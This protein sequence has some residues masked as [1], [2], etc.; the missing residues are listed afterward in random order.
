[1]I[2]EI[3]IKDA[4]VSELI[5]I[6]GVDYQD[7]VWDVETEA[8]IPNPQTKAEFANEEFD[9][10]LKEFIKNKVMKY[11]TQIATNSIDYTLITE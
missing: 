8:Q 1:M 7:E 3:I 4:Y 11:R 9:R 6:F 2:K 10:Q 5:E